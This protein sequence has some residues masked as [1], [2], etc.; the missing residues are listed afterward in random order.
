[1]GMQSHYIYH[2]FKTRELAEEYVNKIQNTSFSSYYS[3]F[4]I[5]ELN[6][7]L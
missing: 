1:M 7:N 4:S 5:E 3:E 2:D 6:G